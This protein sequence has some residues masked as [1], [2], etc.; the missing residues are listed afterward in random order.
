MPGPRKPPNQQRNT[1]KVRLKAPKRNRE[2]PQVVASRP[3]PRY[4]PGPST[5]AAPAAPSQP[6]YG[7]LMQR[8][9]RDASILY[10]PQILQAQAAQQNAGTYFENYKADLAK[11]QQDV[12]GRYQAAQAAVAG[13]TVGPAVQ[14]A[15]EGAAGASRAIMQKAL[16]GLLTSQGAAQGDYLTGRQTV[17]SEQQLQ[18]RTQ[19]GAEV[20]R[21]STEKDTYALSKRDEYRDQA[22][23]R[24]LENKAFGLDT[25]KAAADAAD[26]AADNKR[27]QREDRQ[28]RR[29]D[30]N[31][32]NAQGYTNAEWSAM[33]PDERRAA[34]KKWQESGRAPRVP[35]DPA[36]MTPAQKR[37]A[38]EKRSGVRTEVDTVAADMGNYGGLTVQILDAEGKPTGK[39]R[40][41]TREEV[42]ARLRK[43]GKSQDQI[44]V[45]L[46]LRH[47]D[48]TWDART[49]AAA[50]RLGYGVPK[51]YRPVQST[52]QVRPQ[53][54]TPYVSG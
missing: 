12:A 51:Q 40:K 22:H 29:D 30:A 48:T 15:D 49:R 19:A 1:G 39:T 23:T 17:G 26:K 13:P 54:N 44:I 7:P 21:L 28:R 9:Q 52:G 37:A 16:E 34:N 24:L 4:K 45:A 2:A 38:R 3:Q 11:A 47:K 10:G 6:K 35:E 14:G 25:A 20:N 8:A 53:T 27:Q 46:A 36:T 18:S 43:E 5:P 41:P 31:K 33:T 42:F 50:K 32:V